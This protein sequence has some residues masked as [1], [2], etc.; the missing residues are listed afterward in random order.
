MWLSLLLCAGASAMHDGVMLEE[1]NELYPPMILQE[2]STES[3]ASDEVESEADAKESLISQYWNRSKYGHPDFERAHRITVFGTRVQIVS[4]AMAVGGSAMMVGYMLRVLVCQSDF[5]E[6]DMEPGLITAIVG[7]TGYMTGLGISSVG[8][9]AARRVLKTKGVKV[10]NAG[11]ITSAVGLGLGSVL[12]S[13]RGMI[14]GDGDELPDWYLPAVVGAY[15]AVPVGLIVQQ[16]INKKA[17]MGFV[18]EV[19]LAPI[20]TPDTTGVVLQAQF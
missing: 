10:S 19:S 8:N 3:T 4:G 6:L 18:D 17:Y 14:R 5:D 7:G 13:N 12:R 20:W 2:A 15:A 9:Y 11:F 1:V 16:R